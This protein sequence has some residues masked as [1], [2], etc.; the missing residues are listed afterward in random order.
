MRE[1]SESVEALVIVLILLVL[2]FGVGGVYVRRPGYVG[3]LA[4]Q[5]DLLFV[6]LAVVFVVLILKLTG[7]I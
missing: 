5:G 3:P 4:G 1:G 2:L 7:I 6:L